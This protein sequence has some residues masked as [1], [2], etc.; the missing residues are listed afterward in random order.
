MHTIDELDVGGL[1]GCSPKPVT[2]HEKGSSSSLGGP[3]AFSLAT[4]EEAMAA[5]R[6]Y[7]W[8]RELR[9]MDESLRGWR[10]HYERCL[11]LLQE[12][13]EPDDDWPLQHYPTDWRGRV[14]EALKG[15]EEALGEGFDCHFPERSNSNLRTL[16]ETLR[17][18]AT[19]PESLSGRQVGLVRRILLD[20]EQRWGTPGSAQRREALEQRQAPVDLETVR[21]TLI[22]RLQ[23]LDPKSAIESLEEILAPVAGQPMP[24]PLAER[25]RRAWKATL[26]ELIRDD[27]VDS[28]YDLGR[29]LQAWTRIALQQPPEGVDLKELLRVVSTAFPQVGWEPE[30][31]EDWNRL[32]QHTGRS[33]RLKCPDEPASK[34][35]LELARRTVEGARDTL[36][37]RYFGLPL[38]APRS[39]ADLEQLCQERARARFGTEQP[40]A[41]AE[42]LRL[43]VGGDLWPLWLELRPELDALSLAGRTLGWMAR[44]MGRPVHRKYQRWQRHRRLAHAWQKVVV[45]LSLAHPELAREW[46]EQSPF[47]PDELPP[48]LRDRLTDLARGEAPLARIP[49]GW[50]GE[51]TLF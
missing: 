39:V 33:L 4:V 12:T 17:T 48:R 10:V 47:T 19:E 7:Q 22:A 29:A 38:T 1:S 43:L 13:R 25:A 42:E 31:L 37:Q 18:A 26:P 6:D 30:T 28:P 15:L 21:D 16:A 23:Q 24:R 46:L 20:S 27:V 8:P 45:F 50:C 40:G 5:I 51:Q 49:T 9:R 36:Y 3:F 2:C 14:E 11:A 34:G 35:H 41:A 44:E 32:L